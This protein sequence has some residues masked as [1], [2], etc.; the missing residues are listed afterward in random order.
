MIHICYGLY[1][2]DGHYSKF[3]GTSIVSIF[4][5]T[6]HAV[7]IHIFH[8]NTLSTDNRDKFVYLVGRYGQQIKFYNVEKLFVERFNFLKSTAPQTISYAKFSI[9]AFYRLMIPE[10]MP[11]TIDKVIYLDSGDTLVNLDINVLWIMDV[12]NCPFIANNTNLFDAYWKPNA[13]EEM[14]LCRAGIIKPEKYFGSGLLV[15]NLKYLRDNLKKIWGNGND[16]HGSGYEFFLK[17]SNICEYPDQDIL[18]YCFSENYKKLPS[19]IHCRVVKETAEGSKKI[20]KRIY[21]FAGDEKFSLDA[22]DIFS[23]L[24]FEY[25][26]KTPWFNA[27]IF[28]NI[29][30]SISNIHKANQAVLMNMMKLL[31]KRRVAFLTEEANF[32]VI[33]ALFEITDAENAIIINASKSDALMKLLEILK[34]RK[35]VCF[36]FS[37]KY[38]G[39]RNFLIGQKFIE[40][41]DFINVIPLISG[42]LGIPL[43]SNSI[44][45]SM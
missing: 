31:R 42:L 24:Y 19:H 2:R 28:G 39:F 40:G 44:I 35:F 3:C 6:S 16:L 11:Q 4:E 30:N 7:T 22:K 5:N 36:I 12:S 37:G 9:G 43:D 1:D 26:A 32:P 14:A 21:H 17:N 15:M 33:R 34:D 45:R 38:F 41:Q 23:R 8:D 10:I 29:Y 27:D 25:F 13:S 18:N 20:A